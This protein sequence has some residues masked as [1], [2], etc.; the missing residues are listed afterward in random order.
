M[1]R[2]LPKIPG[3]LKILGK[4]GHT[5]LSARLLPPLGNPRQVR[6]TRTLIMKITAPKGIFLRLLNS[7][8]PAPA[9]WAPVQIKPG[10]RNP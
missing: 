8:T 1:S 7:K 6:G 4:I 9:T 10:G 3:K 5:L 2:R